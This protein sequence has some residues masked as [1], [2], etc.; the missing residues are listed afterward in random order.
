MQRNSLVSV[1]I[2]NAKMKVLYVTRIQH[3]TYA[4]FLYIVIFTYIGYWVYSV[5][6]IQNS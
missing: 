2:Q 3:S 6:T 4:A 5:F 1:K